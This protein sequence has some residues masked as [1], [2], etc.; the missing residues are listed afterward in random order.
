MI[1]AE[2]YT[3]GDGKTVGFALRGHNEIG[4]HGR[5]YNIHCA[6]VSAL[7]QAACLAVGKYLN[8]DVT[9][10]DEH[11]GLGIELTTAPD[12]LTEAIFQTM[13]IGLRAVEQVAPDAIKVQMFTMNAEAEAAL[14]SKIADMKP[15]PPKPLPA[16]NVADV[17]IRAEIFHDAAGNITGFSVN[18]RKGKTVKEFEIYRAGVLALVNAAFSCV[19]DYLKRDAEFDSKSRRRALK[20]KSAPNAV[21]EAVFQTMLIGLREIQKIAPQVI[22]ITE[23][24]SEVKLND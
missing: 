22:S 7:S 24:F 8:R 10:K 15:S 20:L 14:Q 16:L 5:G 21:T 23:N 6:K 11:G 12:D 19:K 18:E 4:K 13:L 1:D 3:Q 2:F 17:R 9:F